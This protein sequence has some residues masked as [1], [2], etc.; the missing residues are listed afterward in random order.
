MNALRFVTGHLWCS[1]IYSDRIETRFYDGSDITALPS[2]L[3]C[4]EANEHGYGDDVY[5]YAIERDLCY[6]FLAEWLDTAPSANLWYHAHGR[7]S[8]NPTSIYRDAQ[9][10]SAAQ[11]ALNGIGWGW[12]ELKPF[13]SVHLPPTALISR[14]EAQVRP[15]TKAHTVEWAKTATNL[16]ITPHEWPEGRNMI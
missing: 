15:R 4:E 12:D 2:V 3:L 14:L 9:R 7:S 1:W 13:S 10:R 8:A 11:A 16:G 5:W 6:N